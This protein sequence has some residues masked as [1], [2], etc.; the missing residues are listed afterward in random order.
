[1]PGSIWWRI[2][3]PMSQP[4]LAAVAI[5]TF[6]FS[7]KLFLKPLIFL[8]SLDMF[9]LPLA[10][11]NFTDTYGLPLWNL[12]LAATTLAVVPILVVYLIAQ[13][14]LSNLDAELRVHTRSEIAALHN[15]LS[16]TM[17]YVT[18]DQIEAMTLADKIVVLRDGLIEQVVSPHE[19]YGGTATCSSRSSSAARR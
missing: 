9:T 18:H 6:L 5:I 7:W 15:R 1:M 12:Q 19:L 17:I 14:P 10:L 11:S 3:L 2:P 8:S 16:T 4:A 13:R